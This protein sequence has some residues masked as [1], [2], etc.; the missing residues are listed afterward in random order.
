MDKEKVGKVNRCMIANIM[1]ENSGGYMGIQSIIF[2][3]S[4]HVY[5]HFQSQK[6]YFNVMAY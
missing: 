4:L 2:S 1:K 5:N 3:D 6:M